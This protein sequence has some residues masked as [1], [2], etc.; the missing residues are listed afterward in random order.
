MGIKDKEFKAFSIDVFKQLFE[1][2]EIISGWEEERLVTKRISDYLR[3]LSF[4]VRYLE[5]PCM[6]WREKYVEIRE[7]SRDVPALALPYSP[8]GYAEAPL[9]YAGHG[10]EKD[11]WEGI[12]VE[13]KIALLEWYSEEL[14]EVVWQYREAVERG[15]VGVIV[16]DAYPG[17]MRRI[18]VHFSED[19]S[20]ESGDPLPVP[21]VSVSRLEGLRLIK[22]ARKGLNVSLRVETELRHKATGFTVEAIGDEDEAITL[23][24][25]HHD[26]WLSGFGDN[27]LGVA[28]LLFL[29][30]ELV[31]SKGI[32]IVSFCC[33]ESGA[34]DYSPWYWV[35]G[36]RNY[37][38]YLKEKG[39]L[40]K[41]KIVINIDVAT[42][43]PIKLALSSPEMIE[44][45][46]KILGK[47]AEYELGSPYFD[48]YPFMV[49]GVPSITIHS[50]D[51]YFDVYHTNK[52][53]PELV[54][55]DAVIKS[56][57]IVKELAHI[58][59]KFADSKEF[60]RLVRKSILEIS[61]KILNEK[62]SLKEA[63]KVDHEKAKK[64]RG[65]LI[66]PIFEGDY[67][68][69]HGPFKTV[70]L[71]QLLI[72]KDYES[73]KR[74]FKLIEEEKIN[75]AYRML[76]RVPSKRIIPGDEKIVTRFPKSYLKTLF[77]VSEKDAILK[78]LKEMEF[79]YISDIRRR[80]EYL[81][82]IYEAICKGSKEGGSKG[83]FRD[84]K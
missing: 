1:G 51:S 47:K 54:E 46:R 59:S 44:R 63:K 75:E 68:K 5:V 45:A 82:G 58:A 57:S 12:E 19:Y 73:L 18:V 32:R 27:V 28:M 6:A 49:E 60:M 65:L 2:K 64:L 43:N 10:L 74:I 33:E 72:V 69:D 79:I 40:E 50:M 71:P 8:S 41:L 66:T 23:L 52:D 30:K 22:A 39:V 7:G 34:L 38:H 36:S 81:R 55:W 80:V 83:Y 14:D 9:V 17:V 84:N 62:K 53:I 35:W 31:N 70:F 13:G 25:A 37:V 20:Y 61:Q 21:V 77:K 78:F 26:H 42:R 11:E 48:S 76:E 4:E 67:S 16:Y 56:Y 15:A 24:T 3:D 29:S